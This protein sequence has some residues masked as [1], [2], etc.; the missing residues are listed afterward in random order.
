MSRLDVNRSGEMEVFVRVAEL[1]GFSAAAR[2]FGMTPSAVSK[3]VAR[4]EQ[5]LGARLLARST[6]QLILTPEG[7]EFLERSQRVLADLAEAERAVA[8]NAAPA[9]KLRVNTNVPLGMRILLPLLPRFL[10][11]YPKVSLDIVL[12]DTVVDLMAQRTDVAIRAGPLKESRLVARK[13]GETRMMVVGAPS[14]LQRHGTPMSVGDL[15]RHNLLRFCYSRAMDD[16][17]FVENGVPVSVPP[18]GNTQVSDGESLR[19]VCVAGLGLARL[20]AWLAREDIEA[21]RLVPVLEHC[22]PGDREAVHA[23]Y[24][25]QGGVPARVRAFLDFVAEEMKL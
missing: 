8:R 18:A 25:R 21:G 10:E 20:A 7:S 17:P 9:G 19:R 23:V 24:C 2:A 11:R 14:Y 1:G 22:N 4:L 16:W 3:L 13:L 12:T 5:R 15:R 6:R